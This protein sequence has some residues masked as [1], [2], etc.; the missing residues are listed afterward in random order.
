[1][2]GLKKEPESFE[3][4]QYERFLPG[5]QWELDV[6]RYAQDGSLITTNPWS[7]PLG[8]ARTQLTVMGAPG[9]PAICPHIHMSYV[10][11]GGGTWE[12][13]FTRQMY[14]HALRD[15]NGDVVYWPS[16]PSCFALDPVTNPYR[17]M[18][19][20][21]VDYWDADFATEEFMENVNYGIYFDTFSDIYGPLW[22][23]MGVTGQSF[24]EARD[25]FRAGRTWLVRRLRRKYPDIVIIGN[26]GPDQDDTKLDMLGAMNGITVEGPLTEARNR[27]LSRAF[28]ESGVR[29][30]DHCY[31]TSWNADPPWQ[32]VQYP[33]V[34]AGSWWGDRNAAGQP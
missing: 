23:Q 12:N 10:W 34:R 20:Q 2:N 26:F 14:D 22:S 24:L 7:V 3:M 27:I 13:E 25:A 4:A 6:D 1:M 30:H 29:A 8:W 31:S 18:F 21:I 32:M 16:N 11:N 28:I 15:E 5:N 33:A 17:T 9:R 19:R